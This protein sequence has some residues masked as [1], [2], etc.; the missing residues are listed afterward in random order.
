MNYLFWRSKASGKICVLKSLENVEKTYE[1]THGL[2]RQKDFPND[3][4]FHMDEA[5]PKD[6]ELADHLGN[7]DDF[8]VVSK[9]LKEFLESKITDP[10]EYLPVTIF[11]HKNRIASKEYY[12]INP[13]KVIDCID[14]E[15]SEIEWNELDDQSIDD[16]DELVFNDDEIPDD[17]MIF[18]PKHLTWAVFIAESLADE[19]ENQ[20]FTGSIFIPVE[21]FSY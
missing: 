19:M 1:L 17:T 9:S 14:Q 4:C 3:A 12:I 10:V 13:L 6:I 21:K 5:H 15:E 11:N 18:R 2:T 20:K 7:G 16:C 8:V